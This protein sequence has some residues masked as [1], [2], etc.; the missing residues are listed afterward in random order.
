MNRI[1]TAGASHASRA[2]SGA[3][4]PGSGGRP[5]PVGA[6]YDKGNGCAGNGG[7]AMGGAA[8]FASG[9]SGRA[10]DVVADDNELAVVE[11]DDNDHDV[12]A[13]ATPRDPFRD[14]EKPRRN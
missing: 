5:T 1:A 6:L 14:G 9:V 10:D 12:G 11:E 4:L 3:K 2:A 8:A 7:G 13:S